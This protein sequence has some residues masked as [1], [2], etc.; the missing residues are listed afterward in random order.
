MESAFAIALYM[1]QPI[2]PAGPKG[3][4]I[5]NLQWM[6]EHADIGDNHNAPVFKWCYERMGDLVPQLVAEGHK[7]RVM[8]DYSGTLLWGLEQMGFEDSIGKLRNLAHN[9][10]DQAEFL[11]T[12]WGHAVAPSTPPAD[13]RL[14]LRAWRKNFARLFGQ[15]ALDNV[16]GF[17]PS[18]MAL[19]NNPDMAYAFVQN[20]R[21]EGFEWVLLQEH[22][23]ELPDGS[24]LRDKYIPYRL[25]CPNLRGEVAEIIGLIKTQGSDTKLVAQMQPYYEAKSLEGCRPQSPAWGTAYPLHPLQKG[26]LPANALTA[27]PRLFREAPNPKILPAAIQIADGE[28]GGVMMNEFP[29]KY[30]EVIR[31]L[32]DGHGEVQILN[33]SEYLRTIFNAGI[34]YDDL[35]VCQPK[36]QSLFFKNFDGDF[37]KTTEKCRRENGRFNMEGG[38]WTNDR[39]WVRGFGGLLGEME[40]A[41]IRFHDKYGS[42]PP[43]D[44]FQNSDL[45]NLLCAQTSCFRYWGEGL[46]P[47]Y[48]R[49]FCR[50]VCP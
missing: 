21:E 13:Y 7:P 11:G 25:R 39:S 33:G 27:A 12:P 14:H 49:E 3:A 42:N 32:G 10:P 18:E 38:S 20:L 4:P 15:T 6:L 1:H 45:F 35:P 47:D 29:P 26:E 46:W 2:I 43:D 31:E 48:G 37:A 36:F 23:V 16:H 9:L 50:R 22:T 17:S 8:L 44:V 34:N 19:P 40:R 28:N 30:R 41:S 24:E 5:N